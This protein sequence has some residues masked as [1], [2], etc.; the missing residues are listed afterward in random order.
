MLPF[1]WHPYILNTE[2]VCISAILEAELPMM[3]FHAVVGSM[4]IL[5]NRRAMTMLPSNWRKMWKE[6]ELRGMILLSLTT[7]IVLVLLGNRRKYVSGAWIRIMVWLAYLLADSVAIMA[8]GILSNDLGHVYGGTSLGVEYEVKAFWA[9]LMLL[10]LG[11]TDTITAY[12]LEDNELWK[13]HSFGVVTQAMTT[14]YILI[15]SWTG[16][17]VSLLFIVMFCFGLVKYCERVWVLYWASENNFRDSINDI[18]TNES[19]IIK[20]CKLKQLEGFHLTTHQVL[21]VEVEVPVTSSPGHNDA[22][23]LLTAYHFLEMV[24]RLFADLILGFQD[25]DASK[26][27]FKRDNMDSE[28]AFKITEIELGLIYDLLY[29]KAKV[30]Y[31]RWGIARRI[32]GIFLT[33][34]VLVMVSLEEMLMVNKKHHNYSSKV[35]LTITMVLMGFAFLLE[36]YAVVELLLSD[37]TAHWLIRHKKVRVLRAI[38]CVRNLPLKR[39]YNICRW[40]NSMEQFSLLSFSLREKP[41]PPNEPPKKK[42]LPFR[43]ILKTLGDID[44]F[45]EIYQYKGTPKSINEADDLK[46]AIFLEIKEIRPWA[47][48]NGYDTHLKSLYGRR[49]GRTIEKRNVHDDLKWSIEDLEFDQSIL[50]WHL[51]TEIWCNLDYIKKADYES[52][53]SIWQ[54][55]GKS[56]SRYMLYLL[57]EHPNMLPIGMGHIRFRDIYVELGD[58]IE[59]QLSKSVLDISCKDASEMLVK[60]INTKDMV[61]VQGGEGGDKSNLV[62]FHACKLASQL[63][64]MNDKWRLI[65]DVWLEM[66]CHAASQ[67]KGR[68]HAQQLRRGGEL[69]T[70]VWLLMAH[71]GL[72]DHFQIP[73]SRAIADA[74]IR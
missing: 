7:Q 37:Q 6:W 43:G 41:V 56:L 49:G 1:I 20:E 13:R 31:T 73:R 58:F 67:C 57:V 66:L 10:H 34:F 62:I 48:E 30:M 71:F 74:V 18:P 27:I 60:V 33:L 46:Y 35:D 42:T 68:L 55:R 59:E 63:E 32:I 69:L 61:S 51:A 52:A 12:S 23:Q 64:N 44:E 22:N 4:I 2:K 14:L 25:R 29:T 19:K 5:Q 36:L 9:P 3:L 50:I 26:A 21:E 45:L 53:G 47:E 65:V 72:T 39:R 16:S 15:L 40:S 38:N 24:R 8:A 28:K 11:G 17:L 54:E 70:H